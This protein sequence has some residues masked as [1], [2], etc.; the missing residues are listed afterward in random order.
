MNEN[1]ANYAKI[2]FFVLAGVALLVIVIAIAGSRRLTQ[3]A[4]LAETFF[5]ESVTGLDIGSAVKYRGVPVGEV[6]RIGFV[7]SAYREQAREELTP[8]MAR[9]IRVVMAL[10]P[11]R[12]GLLGTERADTVLNQLVAQGLRVKIASS[13]MT[14]LAFL[15]MDY[16]REQPGEPVLA[17][18]PWKTHHPFIP[19]VASTMTALKKAVDDV[20]VKLSAIDLQALGDEFL[21]T[22]YLLQHALARTD[23]AALADE[24]TALVKDLRATTLSLK[25]L[26]D[27][28]E[29]DRLPPALAA[30]ADSARRSAERIEAR[31]EPVTVSVTNLTG[32]A[33]CL[34]DQANSLLTRHGAQIGM[35]V[36]AL[37]RTAQTLDQTAATQQGDLV[38]LL[39][40]LRRAAN[41]LERI[42]S[43]LT[44]AP[45]ALLFGRP[46]APL[47]ETREP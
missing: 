3:Q 27:S 5:S 19:A 34:A 30:A 18:Q 2:G 44:S 7:Y 35:T 4:I 23:V 47:P 45:S 32:R 6:K 22:L 43:N 42:I 40:D 1:K 33:A 21:A 39:H 38:A 10:D 14:G 29:L 17:E 16:F 11:E 15:E 46:P 20:F 26:L 28:P 37:A 9:Q 8:A 12:F 25:R 24:T 13:G 41:G 31:I 36:E